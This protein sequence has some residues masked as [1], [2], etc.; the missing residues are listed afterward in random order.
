M[1]TPLRQL[2]KTTCGNA[3]EWCSHYPAWAHACM[4]AG[5]GRLHQSLAFQRHTVPQHTAKM[6]TVVSCQAALHG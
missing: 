4:H 1:S 2:K 6:P 3:H 5:Q